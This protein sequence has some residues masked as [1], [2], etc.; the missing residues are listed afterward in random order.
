M[1]V[2]DPITGQPYFRK[3]RRRFDAD[4]MPREL[5]FSCY[6]RLPLLGRDR[7]RRWFV[8]SLADL[9]REWP[10]DL[11]AWVVMPE[12]VHLVVAP[13]QGGVDIGR[14]QGAIKERTARLAVSW[15]QAHAPE[16]FPR[17]TVREGC[18]VRRRF[19]QPG[20]GYDR[21][22]DRIAMLEHSINYIHMNPVKRGLVASPQDWVW[23][24]ARWY[25]GTRPALIEMDSLSI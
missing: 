19:W 10:I 12:H 7:A 9:R 5:T 22:I 20:G 3:S 18:R 2:H 11:L 13:R 6:K 23:S 14:F 16:W 17:I 25:A 21:N 4:R 8:Q 15:L 24:S 1:L